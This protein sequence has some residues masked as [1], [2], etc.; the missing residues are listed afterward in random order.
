MQKLMIVINHLLRENYKY[1]CSIFITLLLSIVLYTNTFNYP[2]RF[3]GFIFILASL[4]IVFLPKKLEVATVLLIL[5]FGS[6]SV[7]ITPLNDVPDEYVHYAR[8]VY[9]SEGDIN[10]SNDNKNLKVSKDVK[11][12][13]DR[14]GTTVTNSKQLSIKHTK[15]EY[16]NPNIKG[17]NAYYSFSYFP[18]ALGIVLGNAIGF[19]IVITYYLGRLVNL[20]FYALLVF[21]ALKLSGPFKQVI[22]VVALLPMNIYLAASYNQ[23]G[24]AIG[25]VL[26]TIGLFINLL[27]SE[28]SSKNNVKLLIYFGL[29]GLLVLSKFT[30]FLLVLLPFF[31]PNKRFGE[32]SKRIILNKILGILLMTLFAAIWFKLYGQ[33]KT[34]YVADFLKE[35]NVNQQIKNIIERPILYGGVIARHMVT[36]LINMDNIFQF[37]ALSYG[38]TN[39]FS[40]YLVFLFFI[41][42]SNASKMVLNVK[43][44]FG[45]FL[46]ISG[47]IGATVLAMYLTWTPAG[48]LTVLGVQSRYL[49]GI[50]PLLLLLFTSQNSKIKQVEDFISDKMALHVSLLFVIMMLMSTIFR[51]YN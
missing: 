46:V 14:S 41:Y 1:I 16:I 15:A 37:G 21:L 50:I 19:P 49:I 32:R 7:M 27:Y 24:F 34:P 43:E 33:V 36:N 40:L 45:I 25:L 31:I 26:T 28:N 39:I 44:K 2:L 12:I 5:V 3:M 22:A 17:T 47:I 10:L 4:L 48:A 23:D 8:S 11:K 20:I 30:Y 51:Y 6:L 18:Q 35:V 29:C 42:L 9:I 38:I 13:I